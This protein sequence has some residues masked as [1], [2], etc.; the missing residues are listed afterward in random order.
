MRVE[1][2]ARGGRVTERF[3]V[4]FTGAELAALAD[5][6]N[7]ITG[8]HDALGRAFRR[9]EREWKLDADGALFD[10]SATGNGAG[11]DASPRPDYDADASRNGGSL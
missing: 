4:D 7:V 2:E 9:L 1:Y 10:T 5:L 6:A 8:D 11:E 3:R